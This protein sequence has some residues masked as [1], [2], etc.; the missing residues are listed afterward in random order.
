MKGANTMSNTTPMKAE[1][2]DM[3]IEQTIPYYSHFH[4]QSMNLIESFGF[5]SG[6]WLD[7]GCGTG[8]FV[9]KAS[10]KFNNFE[11]TLYDPSEEMIIQAQKRLNGN[12]QVKDFKVLGSEKINNKNEFDI[13]TAIQCHH[14]L[15]ED[16]RLV[17]IQKCYEALKVGGVLIT[18]ENFAPNSEE[19]KEIALRRWGK[20]QN[21][22]GKTQDEVSNH[23][24]RYGKN[25]FPIRIDEQFKVLKDCG[26][27][28]IELF[29]LSY[30]QMGIYGVK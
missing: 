1:E 24:S 19:G 20:Y 6:K 26:F 3:E 5:Y 2:Y 16:E 27:R 18:F 17:A 10:K 13:I 21:E 29:W 23:L 8:A 12:R 11:F 25:Y 28:N 30:M 22:N 15:H 4:E 14:Y 7:T 9:E